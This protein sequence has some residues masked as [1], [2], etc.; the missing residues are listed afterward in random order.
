MSMIGSNFITDI[1]QEKA[2][3]SPDKALLELDRR[4]RIALRQDMED[5]KD[6]MDIALCSLH[7]GKKILHYAGANRP[8]VL[9]RNRELTEHAPSKFPIGGSF[10]AEKIFR[11]SSIQL[12][13][14]DCIYLSTDGYADQ[15]GGPKGKKLMK[16]IF[17]DA[18]LRNSGFSMEMQKEHLFKF[19]LEWKGELEQ[20][21]D[22]LVMGLRIL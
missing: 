9:I 18:L 6:G 16:K 12:E 17:Y 5:S 2:I 13:K 22:V 20:V 21:D 10:N 3:T 15:F 14:G 11:E 1:V 19:F 7:K 8:L 4:V